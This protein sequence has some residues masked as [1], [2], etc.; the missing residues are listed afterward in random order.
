MRTVFA[1]SVAAMFAADAFASISITDS[2]PYT[3]DFDSLAS[4]GS[5][6]NW[7]N[8]STLAGWSLFRRQGSYS[9]M[10]TNYSASTG[11]GN[12]GYFYSYGRAGSTDRA[13][14]GLGSSGPYFGTVADGGVAGWIALSLANNS[15]STIDSILI[16]YDGEQWRDGGALTP[17]A[18]TMVL[19]WGF[20]S[21]FSA[22][23]AW[24]AAGSAF[25]FTSPVTLNTGGGAAVDGNVAGLQAGRGGTIGSLSWNNGDTLW[26]RWIERNDVGNDHALAIDNVQFTATLAPE[27]ST[28]C[29]GLLGAAGVLAIRR[30]R[31]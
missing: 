12:V 30:R 21:T 24:T 17:T 15:G 31:S 26:I 28:M 16:H 27:P 11:S 1:V 9:V 14:G 29:I 2:T 13:L 4:S 7:T 19:E 3:Q 8:D 5:A 6:L 22:V 20:G 10:L 25:N 18:Q 23:S